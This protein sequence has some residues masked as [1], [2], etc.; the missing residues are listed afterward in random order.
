M[1]VSQQVS[2]V[3][4]MR[5]RPDQEPRTLVLYS[6]DAFETARVELNILR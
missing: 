6:R 5:P 1:A 2:K 4:M 3:F